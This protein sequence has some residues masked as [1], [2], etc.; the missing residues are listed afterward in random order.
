MKIPTNRE[1]IESLFKIQNKRGV[2]VPF[3]F[4]FAQD[5]YWGKR[6]RR[7]IILKARQEGLT[8]VVDADQLID[9]IRKP[10][11]AVVISHEKEAASRLF[12]AVKY[13]L[14]N[15]STKPQIQT[16]NKH[17]IYFP[18][19]NSSYYIGAAGQK[20][21]G[22]GDTISRAHLSEA[23][24]YK[25]L[26]PILSGVSEAAEFGQIDIESSPNGR[27]NEFHD[28]WGEAK[29]GKSPYTPIFIPWFFSKDYSVDTL[30]DDERNGLSVAVQEIFNI[31]EEQF[32]LTSEEKEL[33]FK[34]EKDYGIK[35]SIGQLKWRRYKIWDKADLFF[36]EYPED[37]ISCF[38]QSGRP[39]FRNVIL[40]ESERGYMEKGK[41]YYAGLDGAE[42]IAGGDKHCF[43]VI[44]M[45]VNPARVIFEICSNDPIEFFLEKVKNIM[46]KYDID[47]GVEKNGIGYA[48][49][50]KL[51][52]MGIPFKEFTTSGGTGGTR[53]MMI[54]ELEEAYRKVELIE[55]YPEARGEL[56]DMYY[57][58]NNSATHRQGKH[59]DRVFARAIA[60]QRRKGSGACVYVV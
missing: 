29:D 58:D 30:T 11:N 24:F 49:C 42:G 15:L 52:A 5:Y 1:A 41:K 35:L 23:A 56:L 25:H 4:N 16:D 39:V 38:L 12:K 37:D 19:N 26:S 27:G 33:C 55:T 44:D 22:R 43:A 18:K 14:S 7:N 32:V 34:V 20:S 46:L 2:K 13:Y 8:K 17:E 60:W 10:T 21:F 31:P 50:V 28:L 48:H 51:R 36:Q 45:N 59:D 57:D 40:K 47:L 6:T 54:T 9:C 3:K 53:P